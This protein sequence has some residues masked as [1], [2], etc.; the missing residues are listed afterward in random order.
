MEITTSKE[1]NNALKEKLDTQKFVRVSNLAGQDNIAGNIEKDARINIDGRTGDFFGALNKG[2]TLILKGNAG[3]F[4]GYKMKSGRIIVVGNVDSIGEFSGGEIFVRGDIKENENISSEELTEEEKKQ[5]AAL[6]K[7]PAEG[8]KK[9]LSITEKPAAIEHDVAVS[10]FDELIILKTKRA[11]KRDIDI[12]FKIGNLNFELPVF[13][14]PA[15]PNPGF[16]YASC[17]ANTFSICRTD[18]EIDIVRKNNGKAVIAWPEYENLENADCIEITSEYFKEI[19]LIRELTNH[20]KPVILKIGTEKIHERIQEALKYSPEAVAIDCS[21]FPAV[22]I[23]A[24]AR[25]TKTEKTKIL[26]IANMKT[27]EDMAKMLALGASGIGLVLEEKT[28]DWNIV[29]TVISNFLKRT[30]EE[31][32]RTIASAG[33]S[34]IQEF[35]AENIRALTYNA[36]AVTGVKLIGYEKVLPFWEH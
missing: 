35:T 28:G 29:G 20:E 27:S 13:L 19:G 30:K 18:E 25:A 2:A 8:F 17:L 31:I 16:A 14:A 32:K 23:A 33:C 5:L 26:V 7:E 1:I 11:I 36:A 6:L 9:I 3:R 15:K 12:S 24:V 34:S 21:S 4:L 10:A 22:G